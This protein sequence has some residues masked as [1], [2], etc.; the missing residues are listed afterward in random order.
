[1]LKYRPTQ[2]LFPQTPFDWIPQKSQGR[3]F[4]AVSVLTIIVMGS[5][6]ALGRPLQT[7]VAPFGII[8]Y[9]LAGD[10]SVARE[11]ISSWGVQGQASAGLNLGLDFLFIPLYAGAISLGCVLVSRG[12][13][14]SSQL[15]SGLGFLLAWAM[16]FAGVLDVVENFGLIR[17]LLGSEREVWPLLARWSAILKFTLV[18]AGIGY[19]ILG[20]LVSLYFRSKPGKRRPA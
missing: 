6:Q 4:V 11:M 13:G 16:V 19:V 7:Q 20:G 5:L 18:G 17:V 14:G 15:G 3:V 2:K 9:E 12:L 8:S 10:L 1:M